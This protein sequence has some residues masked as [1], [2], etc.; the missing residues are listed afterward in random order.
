M[1]HNFLQQA[2]L[3]GCFEPTSSDLALNPFSAKLVTQ[4]SVLLVQELITV[5]IN[6]LRKALAYH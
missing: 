5:V 3:Q 6:V 1:R 2:Q 4:E